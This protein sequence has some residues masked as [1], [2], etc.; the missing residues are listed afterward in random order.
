[1]TVKLTKTIIFN[2]QTVTREVEI[3]AEVLGFGV[4][5]DVWCEFKRA[6]DT[7]TVE[8]PDRNPDR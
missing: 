5:A 4:I 7:Q 1:M 8:T 6:D 3:T 2:G